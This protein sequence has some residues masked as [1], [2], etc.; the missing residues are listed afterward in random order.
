MKSDTYITECLNRRLLPMI[1]E[2]DGPVLFWPD[3]AS[4]HYSNTTLGWYKENKVEYVQKHMNPPNC[5]EAR[6]IETF[7][8]L[9]KAYL[10]KNTKAED[11][12]KAF[13]RNWL[14]ASKVV[15]NKS[16]L[17]LMSSVRSKVRSVAY[18]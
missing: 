3:L 8:A 11:S 12:I 7:W 10:R 9:T 2:H 14:K 5:P 13:K 15:G 18:N 6:P 16:V 17:K 4:V 1:R